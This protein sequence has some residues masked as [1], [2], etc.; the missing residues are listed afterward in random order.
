MLNDNS[1]WQGQRVC[2]TGG[3]GFLGSFVVEK[4]QARG[5]R[6]VFVPQ[7]QQY[8]LVQPE[9]VKQMLVDACPDVVIHLAAHVGGIGANREHPAE[10]FYDNLVM[11]VHLM[12]EAWKQNVKKFVAIGTV[13]S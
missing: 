1:F 2:V 13:C 11:G 4:L 9:A 12:H 8:N 10:F 7:M 3:A 6:D 5:A